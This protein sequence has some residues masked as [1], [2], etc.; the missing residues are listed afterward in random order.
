MK[1]IGILGGMGPEA[2]SELYARLIQ[3]FQARGALYDEDFPTIYIYSLPAPDVAEK[4]NDILDLLEEGIAKLKLMGSEIITIPCNTATC[5]IDKNRKIP[6]FVSIVKETVNIVEKYGYKKVGILSTR[7]TLKIGE[8]QK[9]F[10]KIGM[11]LIEPTYEE[12]DIITTIILNILSGKKNPVDKK[13][14]ENISNKMIDKGAEVI[15]LGC[16]DLPLIFKNSNI[17]IFDTIQILTEALLRESTNGRDGVMASIGAC[18]AP[19][20]GSN[21]VRGP[22]KGEDR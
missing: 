1:S 7:L 16:T 13:I 6:G 12:Q 5:I 15:I 8:Y 3:E 17:R 20:T 19:R 18:G 2:T 14:L 4:E 9:G 10:E 22:I 11:N 21:P